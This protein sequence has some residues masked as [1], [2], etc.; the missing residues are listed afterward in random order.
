MNKDITIFVNE[1]LY[2]RLFNSLDRAFP[3]MGFKRYRADWHS[4]K[5][6]DGSNPGTPR[7]DK[8]VI[9]S[10]IPGRVL[11]QGGE[12]LSLIDLYMNLNGVDFLEAVKQL[13]SLVG[14]ALLE[15]VR[16]GMATSRSGPCCRFCQ[17]RKNSP[18]RFVR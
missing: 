10:K 2:P 16:L 5:K 9:T 13:C 7:P 14:L 3:Q 4:P 8:S 1:E 12:S 15:G 11:E 17:A 6:I 18:M